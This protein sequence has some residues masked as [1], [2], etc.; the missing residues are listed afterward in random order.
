[1]PERF[2]SALKNIE[3]ELQGVREAL[4]DLYSELQWGLRNGHIASTPES[5]EGA[6]VETSKVN[7]AGENVP[8]HF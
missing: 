3:G 8:P 7:L 4:D 2:L 6:R 1:L 5:V